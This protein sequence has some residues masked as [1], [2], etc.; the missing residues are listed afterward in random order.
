MKG[1][2]KRDVFLSLESSE[3]RRAE[4]FFY[5]ENSERR[6]EEL[7]IFFSLESSERRREIFFSLKSSERIREIFFSLKSSERRREKAVGVFPNFF[8]FI[9][10]LSLLESIS[11]FNCIVIT[12]PSPTSDYFSGKARQ[13]FRQR[14]LRVKAN[15]SRPSVN[16]N[17]RR[18]SRRVIIK[19][20][21][22]T[23]GA[24]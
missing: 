4:I 2:K 9:P 20:G 14:N 19:Q 5:L 7:R 11:R 18:R 22:C 8:A 13:I 10:Q 17:L 12:T 15:G 16:F 21:K 6:R 24:D 23:V 3:R 1:E